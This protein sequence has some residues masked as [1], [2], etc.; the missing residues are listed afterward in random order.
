[1]EIPL[2]IILFLYFVF[3]S[4]FASFYLVIAYHIATSASFTLASFFMS[5]FIFAI[6]I[7]T[8]Y[9]TMELLTGVDFQQSLFTLDLS[10]FSPR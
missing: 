6:T 8:L 1:M 7:L 10:L 4:V 5:F 2:Y 9:G 3:L